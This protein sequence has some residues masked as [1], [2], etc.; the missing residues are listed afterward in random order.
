MAADRKTCVC[1]YA[2]MCIYHI[3]ILGWAKCTYR[4]TK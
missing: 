2:C 3:D 4:W 1:A